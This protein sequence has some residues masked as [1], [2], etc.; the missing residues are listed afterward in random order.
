M[1]SRAFPWLGKLTDEEAYEF[2]GEVIEAAQAAGTHTSFLRA[3]D[4][5]AAAWA[6]SAVALA[7]YGVRE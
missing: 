4:E 3:L 6:A 7:W 1:E 5:R 2:L